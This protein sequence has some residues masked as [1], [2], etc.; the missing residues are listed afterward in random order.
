[1]LLTPTNAQGAGTG[2]SPWFQDIRVRQALLHAINRDEIKETLSRGLIDV[3]HIPMVPAHPSYAKALAAATK[4][5]FNPQRARGLLQEA[6]WIPGADGVLVNQRGERFSFEFRAATGTDT[7]QLQA[8]VAD[9]WSTIG[10]ES[11]INNMS[12]RT[13]DTEEFRNRWPGVQMVTVFSDPGNWDDRFN[14]RFIPTEGNRWTGQNTGRW[15]NPEVDATLGELSRAEI[16]QPS[17]LEDLYVRF[18]QLFSHDLPQLPIRYTVEST[19]YR[20]GLAKIYPKY[21]G[22]SVYTR[23]WNIHEWEWTQ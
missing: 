12:Q 13:L 8:P 7:E 19:T 10:L 3:T 4:Y 6:G 16:L 2:L 21:G 1:V 20:T 14:S 15:A 18:A 11:H 23:T 9:N 22:A 5:D 17:R